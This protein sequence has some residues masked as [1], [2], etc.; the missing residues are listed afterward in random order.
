MYVNIKTIVVNA[1]MPD[2]YWTVR[3]L[4]EEMRASQSEGVKGSEWISWAEGA[5]LISQNP[6]GSPT[7]R[8][9]QASPLAPK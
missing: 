2:G 8:M 5:H 4:V 6:S 9:I 1:C 3:R 7:F